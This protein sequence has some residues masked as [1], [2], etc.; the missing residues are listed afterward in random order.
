MYKFS[1]CF[2]TTLLS[3]VI[4]IAVSTS[5]YLPFSCLSLDS[6][7]RTSLARW[8]DKY[9]NVIRWLFK[10]NFSS[11]N[12]GQ[13]TISSSISYPNWASVKSESHI[14]LGIIASNYISE[15]TLKYTY[16]FSDNLKI[17]HK[18]YTTRD[19]EKRGNPKRPHWPNCK[20]K[21]IE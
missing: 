13:N 6:L 7:N 18:E 17:D 20:V 12:R 4:R 2:L 15:I 19:K 21:Y 8:M 11:I 1:C 3:T 10:L 5:S 9:I 16:L 14:S